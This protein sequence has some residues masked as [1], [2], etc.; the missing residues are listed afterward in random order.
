MQGGRRRRRDWKLWNAE[1][2]VTP[3]QVEGDR[4]PAGKAAVDGRSRRKVV[5][6]QLS[7][8]TRRLCVGGRKQKNSPLK[9]KQKFIVHIFFFHYCHCTHSVNVKEM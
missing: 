7:G 4:G 1:G 3:T 9:C 2:T 8:L 6:D 5:W